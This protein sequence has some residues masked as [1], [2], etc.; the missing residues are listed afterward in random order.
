MR[1]E[2]TMRDP[3]DLLLQALGDDARLHE[4][5][6]AV[7]EDEAR[8]AAR[9]GATTQAAFVPMHARLMERI[10]DD[11]AATFVG[12][13]PL[14]TP[15]RWPWNNAAMQ[16]KPISPW[17]RMAL[18]AAMASL[19]VGSTWS[20]HEMGRQRSPHD[21]KLQPFVDDF[22]MG[23]KSPAPF[24]FTAYDASG[25]TAEA[26]RVAHEAAHWLSARAGI[27]IAVP[28]ARAPG[29]TLIGARH[30]FLGER[31]VAQAHYLQSGVRV[32]LYQ[33]RDAGVGLGSLDPVKIGQRT[34]LTANRGPYRVVAWR[35]GEDVLALVSPLAM[36][37]SLQV[38]QQ[39]RNANSEQKNGGN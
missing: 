27:P 29:L 36:R 9:G 14:P 28:P 5:S 34:Y 25:N 15:R 39:L 1:E 10:A 11:T 13:A 24:E 38:A 32:G 33:V 8:D 37:E 3:S 30:S 16:R 21:L 35:S 23:L 4:V 12:A 17:R 20:A 22:D 19:L 26:V 6:R 31:P 7:R 18:G 2:Q